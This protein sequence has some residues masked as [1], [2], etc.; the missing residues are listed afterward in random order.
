MT[1]SINT[2][3]HPDQY[4]YNWVTFYRV[5][6]EFFLSSVKFYESLLISEKTLID[7]DEHL[8]NFLTEDIRREF[9]IGRAL[10]ETKHY[11]TWLE[12]LLNEKPNAFDIDVSIAH[13]TVR[14]LKSVGKLYLGFLKQKRNLLSTNPNCTSN[15]LSA[16]DRQITALDEALNTMGIFK[17]ASLIPLIVDQNISEPTNSD[18]SVNTESLSKISR[19]KP[20]VVSTIEILDAELR[21][22]CL[23]LFN[24]FQ[25]SVQPERHDTVIA[26]AARILENRLRK[27]TNSTDGAAGL[28]LVGRAFDRDRPILKVS[29]I[30][31]EQEGA[32]QL[33]RGFFGFIRNQF[34]HKLVSDTTP[35]RVLQ[36]LGLVDY[37]ISII[38][39]FG[40]IQQDER[41]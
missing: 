4:H 1:D 26:E 40:N 5:T 25:E 41:L 35:E 21:T 20:Q 7:G 8:S 6:I 16:L 22:R 37:L 10:D 27:L 2:S 19:P 31:G 12:G 24:Q 29:D 9:K 14:Y 28:V 15:L 18:L 13:G 38:N 3:E 36:I 17:N 30:S 39:S 11:R 23:D 33:F 34:S 32:Q